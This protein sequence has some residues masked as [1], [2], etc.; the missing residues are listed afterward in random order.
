MWKDTCF[1][2]LVEKWNWTLFTIMKYYRFIL[3]LNPKQG[4]YVHVHT[5]ILN[6]LNQRTFYAG[7]AR[8]IFMF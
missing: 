5:C 8:L 3:N 2:L 7:A 4:A 6:F 1:I